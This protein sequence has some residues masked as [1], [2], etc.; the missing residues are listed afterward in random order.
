MAMAVSLGTLYGQRTVPVFASKNDSLQFA[1]IQQ[2][3]Q[4]SFAE[5]KTNPEATGKKIDSLFKVQAQLRDRIIAYKTVYD[6]D[7]DFTPLSELLE[8]KVRPSEVTQLSITQA[9]LTRLPEVVYAC[10]NLQ[11]L[12]LIGTR[13]KQLPRKLAALKQLKRVYLYNIA[14]KKN[15][16]LQKN[17]NIEWLV[18]RGTEA[19]KL[20]RNYK[21]L[22][23]LQALDVSRNIVLTAF[24]NIRKNK[25]LKKL[26]A[27][28]N[29][30]TLTDL[31][32]QK[33]STLEELNL[34][35]NKITAVPPTI[36]NFPS[37]K[38]ITFNYNQVTTVD[39]GIGKLTR[40]EELSFY[41]NKL[42]ALPESLCQLTN[43]KSIDLYYNQ[44]TKIPEAIGNMKSLEILYLSNNQVTALPERLGELSNLRELY[45]H[46]NKISYLPSSMHQLSKLR[47][48]R[49]NN[50]AF[51]TFP[52]AILNLKELE[53]LD[54]SENTLH[55]FPKELGL[56]PKIQILSVVNNPWENVDVLQ[57]AARVLKERGAIIHINSYEE[58][59]N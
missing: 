8:D 58:E 57:E 37:L 16:R 59:G 25:K 32:R 10:S 22:H 41:Q 6:P 40:L 29:A 42:T 18:I 26:N 49:I 50:N 15:L 14:P 54:V 11:E 3:I 35:N 7:P 23:S 19:S 56:F 52:Q 17:P 20:P 39:E 48:L 5:A 27:M 55:E 47:I 33:N 13:V 44:I 1:N 38:K 53:N 31:K 45:V 51:T 46:N 43:L 28:E 9:D 36:A 21:N 2:A 4:D 12:E 24:P 30:L 34:Q